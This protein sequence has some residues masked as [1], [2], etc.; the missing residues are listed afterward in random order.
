MVGGWRKLNSEEHHVL[1]ASQTGIIK[2]HEVGRSCS[3]HG[4]GG[5]RGAGE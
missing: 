2:E 3:M 1:Y 5:G 4:G